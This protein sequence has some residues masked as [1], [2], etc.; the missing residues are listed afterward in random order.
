M[1][2]LNSSFIIEN[3]CHQ[4]LCFKDSL[5]IHRREQEPRRFAQ[6]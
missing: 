3:S 5:E 4:Y 1:K 2:T 6:N